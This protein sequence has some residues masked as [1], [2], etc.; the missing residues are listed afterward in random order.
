MRAW[1]RSPRA[2][3]LPGS[4]ARGGPVSIYDIPLKT[5]R[6]E[7]SSLAEHKGKTLLIVNVA[8]RCGP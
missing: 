3:S 5:L 8:S 4:L 2:V 7:P 6:G 1:E